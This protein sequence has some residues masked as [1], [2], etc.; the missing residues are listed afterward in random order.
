MMPGRGGAPRRTARGV[1]ARIRRWELGSGADRHLR[2]GAAA[3]RAWERQPVEDYL[4]ETA[5]RAVAPAL[6]AEAYGAGVPP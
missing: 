1:A 5:D 2:Q 3:L 4:V 6:T